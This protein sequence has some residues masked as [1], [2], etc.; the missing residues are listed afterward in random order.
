MKFLGCLL[1]TIRHGWT[2]SLVYWNEEWKKCFKC[3]WSLF[4]T[5]FIPRN[6][7][8]LLNSRLNAFRNLLV[9]KARKRRR[10]VRVAQQQTKAGLHF[11]T[12]SNNMCPSTRKWP[13]VVRN[14]SAAHLLSIHRHQSSNFWEASWNRHSDAIG[15]LYVVIL[16]WGQSQKEGRRLLRRSGVS[17]H[18]LDSYIIRWWF[19]MDD[20]F[21]RESREA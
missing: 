18:L 5:F 9:T 8:A 16:W 6:S 12:T 4:N 3:R 1:K 20:R 17:A 2:I 19:F 14:Q 7:A 13:I 11:L 21:F 15:T 10:F